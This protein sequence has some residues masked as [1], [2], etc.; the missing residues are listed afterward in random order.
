MKL[1]IILIRKK[2]SVPKLNI[3]SARIS[4]KVKD[5]KQR[6]VLYKHKHTQKN[7]TNVCRT[8]FIFILKLFFA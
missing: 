7:M 1:E 5:M 2:L 4:F 8:Y 6:E 3:I